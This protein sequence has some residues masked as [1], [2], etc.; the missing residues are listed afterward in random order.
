MAKQSLLDLVDVHLKARPDATACLVKREGAYRPV[1]WTQLWDAA[2]RVAQALIAIG[3]YKP[4]LRDETI[5][6]AR[7]IGRVNVD[8]G[9]TGCK[10]PDAIEYIARAKARRAAR[11]K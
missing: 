9:E 11:K 3:I 8:H 7:R 6:T 4:E 10:T 5:E 2:E 1:T